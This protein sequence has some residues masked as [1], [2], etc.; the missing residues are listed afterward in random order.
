[1]EVG[2]ERAV[3]Q[4]ACWARHIK[5]KVE[6]DG[7]RFV[8]YPKEGGV[9]FKDRSGDECGSCAGGRTG[10]FDSKGEGGGGSPA[11]ERLDDGGVWAKGKGQR[12]R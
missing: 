6:V 1:M 3:K 10:W 2:G 5:R 4:C 11:R 8:S 7:E 12:R 9:S